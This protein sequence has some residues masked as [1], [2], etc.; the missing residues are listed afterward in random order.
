MADQLTRDQ[1][2]FIVRMPE[3]LRE[4]IKATAEENGRS[5][6]AEIIFRLQ[7]AYEMDDFRRHHESSPPH[8]ESDFEGWSREGPGS[9]SKI[10]PEVFDVIMREVDSLRAR[11]IKA[12]SEPAR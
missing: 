3:G 8:S 11:L 12:F 6:N 4:R 9:A 5:M 7:E 1:N 2:K 10:D